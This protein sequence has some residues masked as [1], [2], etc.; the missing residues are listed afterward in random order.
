MARAQKHTGGRVLSSAVGIDPKARKD[1]ISGKHRQDP[2][3]P[4]PHS[5]SHAGPSHLDAGKGHARCP[6]CGE[7]Q[8]VAT[9]EF[10]PAREPFGP[11]HC[12][13][14]GHAFTH[15]EFV[16]GLNGEG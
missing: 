13:V 8:N 10:D 1:H 9:G 7:R 11:L 2:P 15:G 12:M 4:M 6:E 14:C 5:P 16:S 3:M